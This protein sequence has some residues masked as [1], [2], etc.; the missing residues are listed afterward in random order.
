MNNAVFETYQPEI[1]DSILSLFDPETVLSRLDNPG[2]DPALLAYQQDPHGF[3]V[4]ELGEAFTDDVQAM[5]NSVRDNV[6]TIAKSA[7]ATGKTH[8]AARVA[9]WFYKCFPG[10]Q[11]YTAAAPPKE[12]LQTLL[13]GE[14]GYLIYNYPQ[15]TVGDTVKNLEVKRNSLEFMKGVAIPSSGTPAEREAKFSGKH[16]PYMLFIFDEGDAI[17]DEVY[18]GTESCMTGGH[19]RMLIMFNPRAAAGTPHRM[20]RDKTAN[21]VSLTAFNHPNVLTGKDII[22][23][24]VSRAVTV[25]RINEWTRPLAP[26]ETYSEYSCYELPDFLVGAQAKRTGDNRLYPPL[27]AGTYKI[28]NP[29]FSYMVLGRYPAQSEEQLISAEW[30]DRA[31]L[32]YDQ[33][34]AQFGEAPPK[35]AVGVMGLDV[36]E[37]GLD[38]NCA[39]RRYGGFV[40]PL[41]KWEGVDPTV[42]ARKAAADYIKTGNLTHANVDGTGVGAGVAQGMMDAEDA[43]I[44]HS[45]KVANSPTEKTEMGEFGILRDQL[46]WAFREWLRTDD[47]AMLP[48]DERLIEQA[49]IPTYNTDDGKVRIM[50]KPDMKKLLQH[51]PDELESVILTF[52]PTGFFGGLF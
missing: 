24:A 44:A 36:A 34:V 26:D 45:I 12:N 21:I 41:K 10:A 35:G 4:D 8:A 15:L 19:V 11:V 46:Y 37:Q 1:V 20:E 43:V 16:A 47:T 28:I 7:N 30:V 31:R 42:T 29:A 32:R 18:K 33:Y 3:C 2:V 39:A 22:P 50:R 52:A 51:S 25:R 48:P 40:P 6:I 9:F 23:G 27:Q 13:W 5:M 14:I 38:K 17:P 49:L